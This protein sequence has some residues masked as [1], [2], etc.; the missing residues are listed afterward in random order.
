[1]QFDVKL[2]MVAQETVLIVPI[3]CET[4]TLWHTSCPTAS[5][6]AFDWA[7]LMSSMMAEI[8]K[9]A[10]PDWRETAIPTIR[11]DLGIWKGDEMVWDHHLLA[12]GFLPKL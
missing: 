10:D 9:P 8:L 11:L 3:L 7:S 6:E 12:S 5:W 4:P 2:G 1:M